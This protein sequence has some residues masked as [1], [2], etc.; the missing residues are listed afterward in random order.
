MGLRGVFLTS[1]QPERTARFYRD[2]AEL[3]LEEVESSGDYVYWKLDDGR[4]QL[5][6]HD[7]QRFADY[8][9][10]PLAASNLTH[11]Y[12]R[13][14]EQGAFLERLRALGLSPRAVDDVVVTVGDPDGRHVMF[15]TA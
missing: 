6:V 4:V 13:I 11:L 10:P 2:V 7:A 5:A 14:P 12:F 15:G 1:D 8:A 9:Y 3:P